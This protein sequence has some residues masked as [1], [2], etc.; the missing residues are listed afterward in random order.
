ME[1]KGIIE[2]GE[3]RSLNCCDNIT[4]IL[5]GGVSLFDTLKSL[6]KL[7]AEEFW[8]RRQTSSPLYAVKYIIL[9][10]PPTEYKSFNDQSTDVVMD[11]LYGKHV[12]GCYSEWTCG[13]GDFDYVANESGHSIFKELEDKTG[14]YIHFQI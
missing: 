11:M 8:E 2:S 10:E 5:I 4:D 14:K 1:L 3:N 12:S 7:D 6:F 9:D 13:Y